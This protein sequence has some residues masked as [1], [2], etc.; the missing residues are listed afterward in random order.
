[1][2]FQ[3]R[4]YTYMVYINFDEKCSLLDQTNRLFRLYF[5]HVLILRTTWNQCKAEYVHYVN[6][7]NKHCCVSLSIYF[8]K[9]MTLTKQMQEPFSSCCNVSLTLWLHNIP[10]GFLRS[11]E[12]HNLSHYYHDLQPNKFPWT[13]NIWVFN[14][15]QHEAAYHCQSGLPCCWRGARCIILQ[16]QQW[17]G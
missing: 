8:C 4:L 9:S 14:W 7:C 6:R 16:E 2:W 11:P 13:S 15:A 3:G 10:Y 1:M 17:T 5:S 12:T